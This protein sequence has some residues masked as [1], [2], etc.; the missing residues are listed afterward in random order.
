MI[1]DL[2]KLGNDINKSQES[3][4]RCNAEVIKLCNEL[5]DGIYN[6]CRKNK[7][8]HRKVENCLQTITVPR[9]TIKQ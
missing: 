5:T 8:I 6:I 1:E 2:N 3:P 9:K 7:K 4:P